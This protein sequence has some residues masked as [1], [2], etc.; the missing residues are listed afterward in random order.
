M[1][2]G[3]KCVQ[4]AYY[5]KKTFFPQIMLTDPWYAS[6]K[7]F[8]PNNNDGSTHMVVADTQCI[9]DKS[10]CKNANTQKKPFFLK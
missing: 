7:T 10:V 8:S 4:K 6:K 3:Q 5:S 1:H 2:L 9:W